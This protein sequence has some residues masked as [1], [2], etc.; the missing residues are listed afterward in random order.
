VTARR[1]KTARRSTPSR[2]TA[3]TVAK[4]A[5]RKAAPKRSR[6]RT[7]KK[8]SRKTRPR[9]VPAPVKPF[10]LRP[11]VHPIEVDLHVEV[12]PSRGDGFRGEIGIELE[13]DRGRR[14]LELHAAD[15]RVSRPRVTVDGR[16]IRGTATLHPERQTVEISLPETLPRGRV[17]LELSFAG[18]LRKDLCGLYGAT[19]GAHRFAFTQLEAADARK[20][21]PCFDESSMKARW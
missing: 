15:L 18:R 1:K 13:L 16:T 17:R 14:K 8:S 10:R 6:T 11:D 7:R 20:F 2:R 4:R 21:F 19:V 9:N 12:D 5:A 3:R